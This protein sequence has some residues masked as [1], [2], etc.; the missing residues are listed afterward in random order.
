MINYKLQIFQ[1]QDAMEE[2]QSKSE[3]SPKILGVTLFSK[4]KIKKKTYKTGDEWAH[5]GKYNG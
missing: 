4:E 5:C 2:H 3:I 1:V